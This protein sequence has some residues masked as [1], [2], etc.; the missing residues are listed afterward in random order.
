MRRLGLYWKPVMV[1]LV[2]LLGFAAFL[3]SGMISGDPSERVLK[4]LYYALSLFFLGG[5]DIGLPGSPST[6]V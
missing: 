3:H 5:M 2:F 4:S 1:T 6:P